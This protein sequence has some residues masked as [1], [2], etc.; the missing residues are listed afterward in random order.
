[1]A[2]VVYT[3]DM[4]LLRWW[5]EYWLNAPCQPLKVNNITIER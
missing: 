3:Y 1:M 5:H 2:E 4:N